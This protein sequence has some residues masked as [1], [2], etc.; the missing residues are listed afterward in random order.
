[1]AAA[2]GPLIR[3]QQLAFASLRGRTAT[4]IGQTF[5]LLGGVSDAEQV[6][7]AA[8]A[9]EVV[10]GGQIAA[11]RLTDAYLAAF[12]ARLV[13]ARVAIPQGIDLEAVTGP[14]VRNGTPLAEVYAR[15]VV[16]VRTM[17]ARGSTL[18]E[19]LAGGRA[20]AVSSAETDV[21]LTSR[22][23]ARE[24]MRA[25]PTI[26]GYSRVPDAGACALCL[27][28]A[29][30]TYH[31]DDL[32]PIHNRCGCSVAPIVGSR[33]AGAEVT[34]E[35][36]PAPADTTIAVHLHGELGPVLASAEHAFTGPRDLTT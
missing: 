12:M 3:R 30:Q 25:D 29:E 28:A 18:T 5:D 33:N 14:A 23:A 9:A 11:A 15:P 31:S 35:G 4:I 1:M 34:R 27:T 2:L 32:M 20:R 19:A 10:R 17:L 26:S 21:Q 13:R 16:T 36:P 6:A 8:R 24:F 22:A 7:F